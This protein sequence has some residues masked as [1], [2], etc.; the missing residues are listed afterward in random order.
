MSDK[1]ELEPTLSFSSSGAYHMYFKAAD[2]IVLNISFSIEGHLTSSMRG[3]RSILEAQDFDFKGGV[4]LNLSLPFSAY[5]SALDFLRD[6]ENLFLSK[7]SNLSDVILGLESDLVAR[8]KTASS[9][10]RVNRYLD[11]VK[12]DVLT[13]VSYANLEITE[14]SQLLDI[15][16]KNY[17]RAD[18]KITLKGQ[19]HVD[20]FRLGTRIKDMNKQ[21]LSILAD[22]FSGLDQNSD[23]LEVMAKIGLGDLTDV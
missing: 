2:K 9:K 22:H 12:K 15:L 17:Y 16:V 1:K 11:S 7:I 6:K 8:K 4:F 19:K 5:D 21:N 23:Y 20:R 18:M 13:S 3:L 14:H 10:A